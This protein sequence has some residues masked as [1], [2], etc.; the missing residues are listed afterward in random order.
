[1]YAWI[2]VGVCA[3]LRVYVLKTQTE[4]TGNAKD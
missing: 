3:C 1:M 2:H 4:I